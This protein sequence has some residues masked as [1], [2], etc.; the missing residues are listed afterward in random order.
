MKYN[1]WSEGY[2]VTGMEGIPAKAMLVA[3]DVEGKTFDDA[4]KNWVASQDRQELERSWGTYSFHEG[5]H[6]LWGCRL[7]PTEEEA[8]K[9]FG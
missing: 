9:S 7:F 6:F 5:N 8:R 1:I 4:V 3:S 2:L